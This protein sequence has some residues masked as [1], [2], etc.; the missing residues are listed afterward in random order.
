MSPE[1]E[2]LRALVD[3]A[4]EMDAGFTIEKAKVGMMKVLLFARLREHFQRRD[5]LR[6]V[7]VYRREYLESLCGRAR[8]RPGKIA[9]AE[10][11]AASRSRRRR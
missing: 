8:K 6:L 1:L 9:Q 2:R 4:G 7:A 3:T 5:R 11:E 10:L